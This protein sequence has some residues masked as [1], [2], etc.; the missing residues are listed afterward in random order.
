MITG[1]VF[2]TASHCTIFYTQELAPEGYVAYVSL[3]Q[4]IPFGALTIN[5]TSLLTVAHVVTN[6]NYNQR[7]SFILD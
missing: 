6:P 2:L 3:D 1:T 7:D 4:S 5:K